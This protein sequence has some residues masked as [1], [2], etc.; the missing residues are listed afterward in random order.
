MD[1]IDILTRKLLRG[2][3]QRELA[4]ELGISPGY[5]H[6]ILNDRRPASK[7]VLDI[8]GIERITTYRKKR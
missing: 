7:A 1:P 3:T 4:A 8:L 6:D 2:K 5:L